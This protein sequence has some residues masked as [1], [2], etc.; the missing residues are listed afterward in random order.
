MR[1][2]SQGLHCF[3]VFTP[4]PIQRPCNSVGIARAVLA[5]LVTLGFLSIAS[6]A[7]QLLPN[8]AH[9]DDGI[10]V[11]YPDGW[12]LGTPAQHSWVLLNVPGSELETVVPTAQ[13][14]I[15]YL[16]RPDAASAVSQLTQYANESSTKSTFL[17]IDGWPAL[18]RVQLVKRHQPGEGERPPFADPQ[19]VNITTAVA[20]G[21]LVVRLEGS[22]PSNANQQ[23]QSLVLAIGQSL[24]FSSPG[25]GPQIQLDLKQLRNAATPPTAPKGNANLADHSAL[26]TGSN[27]PAFMP[28]V[29]PPVFSPELLANGT[30]GE[31]EVAVSNDGSN[32]VVVKQSGWI[33]SNDGGATFPFTGNLNVSDGDS[34]IAFGQSG[35]F[36]HA[37]LSCFSSSCQPPCPGASPTGTPASTNNCMA[38]APS[39]TKGQTFGSLVNAAICPNSGGSA[40]SLDQEHIAADRT[41]AGA[42][43][44]DR[45]YAAIRN[46]QGGCGTNGVFVTC[47]PDS[48]SSWAPL[49]ELEAGSDYPRVGVGGDGFFYVV[50]Q[51]GG[52]IRID[53]FNAC[54]TSASQM[55]R[56]SSSF[57]LTVSSYSSFTG[58]EVK[59]GF[60]GLD[61]CN[62]GNTLSGPTVTVDD[63]N[64]NHVYVAWANN[65]AANNENILVADSTTGGTS[66]RTPVTV[67]SGVTGR[68]YHAWACATDGNAFVSWYDRRAATAA[69][70]DLTD[71][72]AA[73][74]GLSGST[75]VANNDEFK[76]STTSDP[77]CKIWPA[78]VRSMFDSENCSVQPELAGFCK[79]TPIPTPDTSSNKRCDFLTTT[80]PFNSAGTETCQLGNFGQAVKYGDYN[81]NAC[82]LGRLYT[83]FASGAGMS[84]IGDFFQSFV[85]GSTKTTLTYTGAT[86]GHDGESVT[87]SAVLTLSGTPAGIGGQTISF[88]VGTQNCS[89]VTNSAGL[90]FCSIT[91]TQVPGVYTVAAKFA[92]SGNYQA[93]NTSTGF[94]IVAPPT[95]A[96]SFSGPT[97]PLNH[98]TGLT[99]TIGN[100]NGTVGLSGIG[101]ADTLPAGLVVSTPNGLVGSCGGGVIVAAAGS[102]SI[103]LSGAAL[104]ASANCVFTVNVTGKV[105]GPKTNTTSVITSIQ[106]GNGETASA[107]IT[108]VAPPVISKAFAASRIVIGDSTALSFTIVNPNTTV[109][110]TSVGFTDSLPA[111]L[112]VATPNG[113][114]GSCG[115]G[116]ITATAGSN[117]ISLS[118]ATLAASSSCTFA[119]NVTGTI[120]GTYIN[121]TSAVNSLDGGSGNKASATITVLAPELTSYFSNANTAGAPDE[122][123]QI[124]NPGLSGGKLCADIFVFDANQELA[125]CCSCVV[126]PDGLL[127]LSMD[128]DLTGNPLTGTTLTTGVIQIIPAATTGK[129]CP[130]P[131][132]MTPVQSLRA[133]STHIQEDGGFTLTESKFTSTGISAADL[134]SLQAQCSFIGSGGSGKGICADSA[135]LASVCNN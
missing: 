26:S 96:K 13:V 107:S 105:A 7:Q 17:T 97:V 31:L 73:S 34:S 125:E 115:G 33:T 116:T 57:P 64:A 114:A 46:C 103:S 37:A 80:C 102:S 49:L 5:G 54:T 38:V 40:C 25:G 48:D 95:I 132:A 32:I 24:T 51:L 124:T 2:T 65:T 27:I 67:S 61:R 14:A 87:L 71:Y 39:T 1:P 8:T 20:A 70:N 63:T 79:L 35:N 122:T 90:A 50:Y 127:T 89:G 129:L 22:L 72:F 119:V 104:G 16:L 117:S 21:N 120:A 135:A 109:A 62:D 52:N 55:T 108:V 3:G 113:L 110:L 47:S 118:G 4:S 93:S 53:K 94:T 75:L 15:G 128:T 78:G 44:K 126:S 106:G 81:G 76:I 45:V 123:V 41:N 101:F 58:C 30:N 56:A 69:N 36:Y 42:G 11:R 121:T 85:V 134:S 68:R 131:T 133:W 99:F 100:P 66:F 12:S 91:L 84:S 59:N 29:S 83:V 86:A 10:S 18:Q 6:A 112:V 92:G 9:L 43:G 60:G 111:G 98:S 19:M 74:A 23:L 77:Q 130:V 28:A 88:S 82:V